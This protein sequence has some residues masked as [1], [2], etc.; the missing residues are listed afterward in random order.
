MPGPVGIRGS[1]PQTYA[2]YVQADDDLDW[3]LR[4][5]MVRRSRRFR[6]VH[7]HRYSYEENPF[8]VKKED[9]DSRTTAVWE[10]NSAF[11][12]IVM[13]KGTTMTVRIHDLEDT[14]SPTLRRFLTP[15][16]LSGG[17]HVSLSEFVP[18]FVRKKTTFNLT[19]T[20]EGLIRIL[21]LDMLGRCR[22]ELVISYDAPMLGA[23]MESAK[24][25]LGG[26]GTTV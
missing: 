11:D 7:Y 13:R 23:L 6:G 2:D 10:A 5:R 1:D 25:S 20:S 26:G 22:G 18:N 8:V 9:Y 24:S 17:V 19:A 4:R 12:F 14:Q 21:A 16:V 3:R 15:H